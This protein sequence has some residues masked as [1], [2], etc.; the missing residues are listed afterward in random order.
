MQY[1]C[2]LLRWDLQC[3][4]Q[5]HPPHRQHHQGE[6]NE[7]AAAFCDLER[8]LGMRGIASVQSGE[9]FYLSITN[10]FLFSFFLHTFEHG[11]ENVLVCHCIHPEDANLSP[12]H[13]LLKVVYT[14]V[15]APFEPW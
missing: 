8:L 12:P 6:A 13:I 11:L 9:Q 14:R 15:R 10:M 2:A 5:G 3:D 1:T 4:E 7:V